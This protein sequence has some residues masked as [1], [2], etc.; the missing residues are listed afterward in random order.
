MPST[1]SSTTLPIVGCLALP[2]RCDRRAYNACLA[3]VT[4]CSNHRT[5]LG[6][7]A[8]RSQAL[9]AERC[10]MDAHLE[11]IVAEERAAESASPLA[12]C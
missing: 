11:F 1:A 8:Y 12:S 2:L 4:A 7:F 10:W 5:V 9:S 3:I 6:P